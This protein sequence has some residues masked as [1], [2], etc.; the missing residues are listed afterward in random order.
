MN[1]NFFSRNQL[2]KYAL[3]DDTRFWI[4]LYEPIELNPI[5]EFKNIVI[6][7]P[8][9]NTVSLDLDT[10]IF[11]IIDLLNSKKTN[12]YYI[13][14]LSARLREKCINENRQDL[15]EKLDPKVIEVTRKLKL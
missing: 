9:E 2:D 14:K 3:D 1:N 13:L 4:E 7:T 12:K 15:I 10:R 6:D 11:A 8:Y 5:R